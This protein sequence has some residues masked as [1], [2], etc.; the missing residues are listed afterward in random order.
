MV[1]VGLQ[2]HT[3]MMTTTMMMMMIMI[4][5]IIIIIIIILAQDSGRWRVLVQAVMIFGLR[6]MWGTS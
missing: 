3:M 4:I 5:I 6:K 2:R 1:R